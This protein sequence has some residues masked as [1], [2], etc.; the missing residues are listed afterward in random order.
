MINLHMQ[1]NREEIG[2]LKNAEFIVCLEVMTLK[3]N[4]YPGPE[5]ANMQSFIHGYSEN[6]VTIY[7]CF[8][9]KNRLKH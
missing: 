7:V 6:K 4:S 8:N 9:E 3:V 2:A 1:T 5:I